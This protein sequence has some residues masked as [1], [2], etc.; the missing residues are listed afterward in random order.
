MVIP[1]NNRLS[2]L[3]IADDQV[4]VD[5]QQENLESEAWKQT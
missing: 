4:V 2:T 3:C 1:E 5:E